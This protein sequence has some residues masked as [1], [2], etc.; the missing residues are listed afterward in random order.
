MFKSTDA[1][2]TW[3]AVNTGLTN[4]TVLALAINPSTPTILYAGTFGGVFKST[5]AGGSW[6]IANRYTARSSCAAV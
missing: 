3:T 4:A 5:N 1:G 6:S 2:G